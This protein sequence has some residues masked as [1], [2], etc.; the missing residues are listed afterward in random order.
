MKVKEESEKTSSKFNIQKAKIMASGPITSWQTDGETTETMTDY[1]LGSKVTEDGDCSHEVK[2]LLIPGRKA[3]TEL[4]CCCCLVASVV[5]S[6][7]RPYGPQ[8]ARLLCPW[9]SLGRS[10]GVGCHALLQGIFPNQG[11]NSDFLH[12]RQILYC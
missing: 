7:V 3:V 6:S 10:A 1:L 5:P 4:C 2:R 11:P 9:D 8:P 12:C